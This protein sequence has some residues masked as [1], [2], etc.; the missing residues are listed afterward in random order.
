[1]RL[2]SS[3]RLL[4]QTSC[5]QPGFNR[6]RRSDTTLGRSID[7]QRRQPQP[8]GG[9]RSVAGCV[10]STLG[11]AGPYREASAILHPPSVL[12][13]GS[14]AVRQW[15]DRLAPFLRGFG[16]SC[17]GP[18]KGDARRGRFL[19]SRLKARHRRGVHGTKLASRAPCT[20]RP[21][22]ASPR[23]FGHRAACNRGGTGH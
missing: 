22:C 23:T 9:R 13:I 4:R 11:S 1:M 6:S 14:C 7:L 5:G 19:A 20:L 21:V 17:Q 18:L 16:F 10:D 2:D 8:Y 3:T 12:G 15:G